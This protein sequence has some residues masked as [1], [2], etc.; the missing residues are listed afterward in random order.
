[1]GFEW[2]QKKNYKRHYICLRCQKGFKRPSIKEM[3][4]AENQDFSNLMN[5]YY[6]ESIEQDIVKYINDRYQA[7]R[8]IC[9]HCQ[10]QM[11]Q[12]AYDFEVPSMRDNKSWEQLRKVMHPK[13]II[14]YNTYIIWHQLELQKAKRKTARFKLLKVNLEKLKSQ[15]TS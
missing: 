2:L 14:D 12:V 1:M 8:V 3:K 6:Q 5:E 4:H 7:L 10:N 15:K 13:T 11:L 9:P